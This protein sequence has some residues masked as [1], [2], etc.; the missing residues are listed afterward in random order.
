MPVIKKLSDRAMMQPP[1]PEPVPFSLLEQFDWNQT[2][3]QTY[4]LP[5]PLFEKLEKI[6]DKEKFI[7]QC[8]LDLI[9]DARG[10]ER[11][12]PAKPR[13]A[14]YSYTKKIPTRK[15]FKFEHH[16]DKV[17]PYYEVESQ[18]L[19]KRI[20]NLPGDEQ[21]V[22]FEP[23]QHDQRQAGNFQTPI[24]LW[25]EAYRLAEYF[26][27]TV[28]DMFLQAVERGIRKWEQSKPQ[29]INPN[30]ARYKRF[31]DR[32]QQREDRLVET[33]AKRIARNSEKPQEPA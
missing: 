4:V 16:D 29:P 5:K 7:C 26:Q 17:R 23:N 28:Y 13:E 14:W 9:N 27:M 24:R 31:S 11:Q 6:P 32:E 12:E 19:R 1:P 15:L 30:A 25:N 21:M 10:V 2:M 8:L 22:F 20:P 18:F 3:Y 33:V